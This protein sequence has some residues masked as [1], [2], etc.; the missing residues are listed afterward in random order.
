MWSPPRGGTGEHLGPVSQGLGGLLCISQSCAVC[1]LSLE[2]VGVGKSFPGAQFPGRL[3]AGPCHGLGGVSQLGTGSLESWPCCFPLLDFQKGLCGGRVSCVSHICTQLSLACHFFLS[4]LLH[5]ISGSLDGQGL[6]LA[7]LLKPSAP[8]D[9]DSATHG[10][11]SCH[12]LP[13]LGAVWSAMLENRGPHGQCRLCLTEPHCM[14]GQISQG[15]RD[16]VKRGHLASGLL[17]HCC[18]RCCGHAGGLQWSVPER[19]C[20]TAGTA[21]WSGVRLS[22]VL[23]SH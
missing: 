4:C 3:A 11:S 8:G 21:V 15:L 16:P 12:C 17:C 9:P 14:V 6:P 18:L 13:D 5:P 22:H 23:V 7:R 1:Y 19:R 2:L 20:G 10:C